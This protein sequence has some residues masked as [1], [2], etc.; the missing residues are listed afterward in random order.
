MRRGRWGWPHCGLEEDYVPSS[1]VR[2]PP[3]L[4]MP[5]ELPRCKGAFLGLT[6]GSW[7]GHP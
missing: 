4:E 3:K 6:R 7:L 5:G 2:A 1:S